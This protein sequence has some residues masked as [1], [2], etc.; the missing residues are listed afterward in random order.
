[1]EVFE[2]TDQDKDEIL[3]RW[4]TTNHR[5]LIDIAVTFAFEKMAKITAEAASHCSQVS[6]V[7]IANP[8]P[9]PHQFGKPVY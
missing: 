6:V 2:I 9:N 3:K 7:G 4:K 8:E 1:M 5:E